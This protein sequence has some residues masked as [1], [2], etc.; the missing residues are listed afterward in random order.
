MCGCITG[1]TPN[2]SYSLRAFAK[3]SEV[4]CRGH[5]S[6]AVSLDLM[7]SEFAFEGRVI[8]L[9]KRAEGFIHFRCPGLKRHIEA[10][11]PA[12]P[13][14]E[15]TTGVSI[16]KAEDEIPPVINLS[17]FTNARPSV[18][19]GRGRFCP[20]RHFVVER[21][22]RCSSSL[23]IPLARRSPS[24]SSHSV[25]FPEYHGRIL[26][27][28]WLQ[29][30]AASEM[31]DLFGAH[32]SLVFPVCGAV[33]PYISV[34][35]LDKRTSWYRKNKVK[36]LIWTLSDYNTFAQN[37]G[38]NRTLDLITNPAG[39]AYPQI[40]QRT[41]WPL[42]EEIHINEARTQELKSQCLELVDVDV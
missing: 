2:F 1:T 30:R 27:R 18:I 17:F 35:C 23:A 14:R 11:V 22:S 34:T 39:G 19:T 8:R 15:S 25:D 13:G 20:W 33:S 3:I 37:C 36:R 10:Y 24:P 12:A 42:D 7:E 29:R 5:H 28:F 26:G 41:L 32:S 6:P 4:G 21:K 31:S 38:R 9:M 40:R 16:Y